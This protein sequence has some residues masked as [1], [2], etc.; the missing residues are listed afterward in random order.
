MIESHLF[1]TEQ[2][3]LTNSIA[4]SAVAPA[5]KSLPILGKKIAER[6]I[7]GAVLRVTPT[8][9]SLTACTNRLALIC[10]EAKP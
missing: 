5:C 1:V 4:R 6:R 9:Q 7:V 2:I 8:V 3:P 10:L